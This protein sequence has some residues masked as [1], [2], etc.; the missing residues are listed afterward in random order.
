MKYHFR[1]PDAAKSRLSLSIMSD[2]RWGWGC[3]GVAADFG[4]F[5]AESWGSGRKI[6]REAAPGRDGFCGVR[7]GKAKRL[8]CRSGPNGFVWPEVGLGGTSVG[9]GYLSR[10]TGWQTGGTGFNRRGSKDQDDCFLG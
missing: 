10:Q 3:G 2:Y 5:G 7:R 1:H 9:P 6:G 4:A 8:P